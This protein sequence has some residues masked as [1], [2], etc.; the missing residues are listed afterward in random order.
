[1]NYT[2]QEYA[3]DIVYNIMDVCDEEKV[4]HP[5][6]VSESGRAIVAHHSVLVVEAFGAIEKTPVEEAVA[7]PGKQHKLVQ[8]LIYIEGH[9]TQR[10]LT[11]IVA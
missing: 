1:M 6:I 10:N 11:R 2:V 3:N 5:D 8:D 7:I 9:L 4:P